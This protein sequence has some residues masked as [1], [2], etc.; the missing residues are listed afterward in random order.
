MS[1][2]IAV[3]KRAKREF[4]NMCKN[5]QPRMHLRT[6]VLTHRLC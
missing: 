3:Q 4:G 6:D 1:V 5:S 2:A